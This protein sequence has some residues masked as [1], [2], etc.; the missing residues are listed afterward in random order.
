MIKRLLSLGMVAALICCLCGTS[1]FGRT[2]SDSAEPPTKSAP[3]VKNEAN[4][5]EKLRADMHKLVGDAKAGKIAPRP[6]SPFQQ[7]RR[8]NLST[9]AK[10]AIVAGIGALIF[11]IIAWR[12]LNSDN[13]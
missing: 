11:G 13:D 9:G 2:G 7:T 1:V 10:I 12:A 4:P 8:N 5:N 6:S 3:P